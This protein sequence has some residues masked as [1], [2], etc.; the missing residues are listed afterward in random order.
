MV[1]ERDVRAKNNR[2]RKCTF[3]ISATPSQ[4]APAVVC[5]STDS[6]IPCP[7]ALAAQSIQA[8]CPSTESLPYSRAAVP[9]RVYPL[10]IVCKSVYLPPFGVVE[11]TIIFSCPTAVVF[12]LSAVES[13]A[14]PDIILRFSPFSL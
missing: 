1:I 9:Q 8:S 7:T 10:V 5:G 3:G 11:T 2:S 6:G 14:I 12:H 4:D 13:F